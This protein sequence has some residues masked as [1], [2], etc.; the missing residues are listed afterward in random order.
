MNQKKDCL[1]NILN[2]ETN[3][4]YEEKD[5]FPK[6]LE[7]LLKPKEGDIPTAIFKRNSELEAFNIEKIR[8]VIEK[9]A[10]ASGVSYDSNRINSLTELVIRNLTRVKGN[11]PKSGRLIPSVED[12]QDAVLRSF[13]Q[14]NADE[15][16]KLISEKL[17]I[18]YEEAYPVIEDIVKRFDPTGKYY[19]RY[20][21]E[22]A[23]VRE[24]MLQMPFSIKIDTTDQQL[25]LQ[26]VSKGESQRFNN[27]DLIRLIIE[28]TGVKYDDAVSAVKKVERFLALRENMN[29][30]SSEEISLMIDSALMEKG[31]QGDRLLGGRRIKLTIDD[32]NGMVISKSN[33][34]SNIKNN[35]PEAVNLG[36]AELALKEFALREIYDSD[37]ASAHR[38]G[39]IHIHD[40]GY[41]QRVYCSAH[42]IEYIKKY[43]LKKVVANLD[44]KSKPAKKPWTLNNHLHTFLAAMQTYYAGALGFPMLNT[45]YAPMMLKE[46]EMVEGFEVLRG[47]DGQIER[48]IKRR[49]ES[50]TLEEIVN[51]GIEFEE[52]SRKK[53]LK[54]Y[55]KEEMKEIAQNLIFG[56]AQS[57]FSRGGQTL[58]IDFN[59]DSVTPSYM[60]EVP[61]LFGGANYVKGRK[62]EK[63]EWEVVEKTKQEPE[64]IQKMKIIEKD[65]KKFEEPDITHGDV[66]HPEDGTKYITYGT[67]IVRKAARD[68]AYTL[69]E[70]FEEGDKD[71]SPF[72]FPKC[73][74]HI[75]Q[76][77]FTDPEAEK[78]LRRA[79]EV[80]EKNDSVYFMF[81]RGDGM[82]VSQ[83][84][85]LR[86]KVTDIN[87]L[88]YPEKLRFCGF[89]NVTLNLPQIGYRAVG[90]TLEERL[91]SALKE[92]DETMLLA[93][94]AHTNKRRYI[95]TLLESEGSPLRAVG[96]E[97]D[98]GTPYID[99]AKSTY[100]F[101]IAGL[102]EM[103]QTITGKE[104]HESPE[105]Y[106]SGLRIL[107]HIYETTKKFSERYN[108]KC[109]VEETPGESANRRLAKIDLIKYPE[110]A[111][112]VLKGSLERD[113][114]Y[115]TNSGHLRANAPVTGIDRAIL[116]SKTNP[117]IQ[118]GAITHFFTGDRKNRA[119]AI[120][121]TVK[122]LWENT[123][124]A[125]IV[126]SGEHT[127]CLECGNHERGLK[128]KCGRCGNEEQSRIAKKTRVVGYFS[129]PRQWNKSKIGEL[130]DRQ[131]A[132]EFYAGE[133]PT[134][135]DPEA[136]ILNYIIN[137]NGNN[138]D[139]IRIA[140]VGTKTCALCN[141][142]E[143]MTEQFVK[144]LPE[145][146]KK[147]IEVIKYDIKDENDRVYACIYNAPIDI[148]PSLI[149]HKG[150]VFERRTAR[151]PYRQSPRYI[152]MNDLKEMFKNV[153]GYIG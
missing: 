125:Q 109:V 39:R 152:S 76:E 86:E 95:Q 137:S 149:V 77:T 145:D 80:T 68:F 124:S 142:V 102:N 61:A 43:G 144:K 24:K 25:R 23:K 11:F 30:I 69:L 21:G 100:I 27:Q 140:I 12:V 16:T 93:L 110:Q 135:Y 138:P 122:A 18:N 143:K 74:L 66:K 54:E 44:A 36:I 148:Y 41:P 70:I 57:A 79:C 71:G 111:K 134:V 59:I 114:V 58:F 52:T 89:Q 119:E 4:V 64:R 151:Y 105:A 62:N 28:R 121:D 29:P 65:G 108:M 14:M 33:E 7:E 139:K 63:G 40:L 98:D 92:I 9:A 101:G 22:R 72:N 46:V 10:L 13:N 103:V 136:N 34:N 6:S 107:S 42:S 106:I 26:D 2:N 118:A 49:F 96:I 51:A 8:K 117:M 32:I 35:N 37:V 94:K 5:I 141:S 82:N 50:K 38:E 130:K 56:A 55:S 31:Y 53:I 123:Q 73:D 75:N 45:L 48:K 90:D 3:L 115:Y 81:D 47:E 104:L 128:D 19:E 88:K 97:S 129:D 132:V 127:I 150:D 17:G 78:L 87:L 153:T 131:A 91:K 15:A 113:E 147:N 60:E 112:K 20:M 120:Y 84:C 126:F 133:R 116:Q 83:C 99:L 85:R 146:V 1:C 67:D